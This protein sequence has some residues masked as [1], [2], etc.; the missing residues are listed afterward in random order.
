MAWHRRLRT[1]SEDK[2][3]YTAQHDDYIPHAISP[4]NPTPEGSTPQWWRTRLVR[5][6]A[7]G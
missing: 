6:D 3:D 7:S 1:Y 5:Y 4:L 2:A